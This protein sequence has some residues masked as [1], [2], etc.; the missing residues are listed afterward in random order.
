MPRTAAA[1]II[2]NE[3]LSGKIVDT[4]TTLLARMLFDLGIEL[5][6]V[7]VC[8]DE[9]E[10]I[11]KDLGELRTTHDFVFTSGGVGPTHDDVTIDGV[12][13]SF[14]RPVVR[15]VATEKMIRDYHGDRTTEA[16]LRMANM[17]E[18]A[19][20]IRSSN[21]PWPTVVIENVFVLPGVPEIFERKLADL[22]KRLD[23]GY[24][25]HSQAVYTLCDEGEI[26]GLL[27]RIAEHSPGVMV[28]SYVKWQAEDYRTKLTFDGT[29]PKLVAE[30]ADM[31]V[32]ELD[33]KLFVRRD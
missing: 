9:I 24:E 28:G 7:V 23:E 11:G 16:H 14:G 19:E 13:E 29:D 17:P 6:R 1:L 20:M 2:G 5:R 22:R 26:A 31:L 8:P 33:P 10:T 3:I 21:A 25:F 12:A 15:S 32:A 30:A 4:N 27:E 18:G